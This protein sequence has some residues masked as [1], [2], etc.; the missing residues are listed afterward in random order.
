MI[1]LAYKPA[2]ALL[3]AA[4]GVGLAIRGE[5][6]PE[7]LA[8]MKRAALDARIETRAVHLDPAEVLELVHDRRVPVDLFDLRSEADYNLF[9]LLDAQRVPPERFAD[10][11]RWPRMRPLALKIL[12]ANDEAEAE[13]VW[14]WLE[15]SGVRGAYVLAG[16]VNLW[17]AVFRDG[18]EGARPAAEGDGRLR[19]R[20]EAALGARHPFARPE[21]SAVAGR[22]FEEKAEMLTTVVELAGGCGG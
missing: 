5:P 22:A 2:L 16:G 10:P 6:G 18:Q 11:A 3:A 13:R 21:R 4:L 7:E 1:G 19:H 14:R 15:A 8:R 17:L 20:F 12:I 9:H